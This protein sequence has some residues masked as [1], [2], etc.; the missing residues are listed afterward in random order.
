MLTGWLGT[1]IHEM[2]HILLCLLFRHSIEEVSFFK[3]DLEAKRLGYVKHG[4]KRGNLYQVVGNFFI[5]MAPLAGG[6][7]VLYGLLWFFY[8]QARDALSAEALGRT[9]ASGQMLEA[10]RLFATQSFEVLRHVVTLKHLAD[11]R[12]W[13]FFYLALCVGSHLAPSRSDYRGATWGGLL[14]V[15]ILLLVNVI[16][17]ACGI[18]A[19]W[20]T[21]IL[22]GG[23][24]H[25]TRA[26]GINRGIVQ[27]HDDFDFYRN[28][29][30]GSHFRHQARTGEWLE[31][32]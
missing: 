5:G 29:H 26:V 30:L 10:G 9:I 32:D 13:L 2:S 11:W 19:G 31:C 4:Y 15:G 22:A 17:L 8:P 28:L 7:L 12:L 1:P 23:C 20:L 16:L 27:L 21:G 25:S 24:R 18:T 14:L 6:A 3:P